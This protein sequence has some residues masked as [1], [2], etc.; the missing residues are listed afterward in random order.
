MTLQSETDTR[1][2]MDVRVAAPEHAVGLSDLFSRSEVS[3]HCR[4]WHFAGDKN[5]W[6]DR[7]ANGSARNRA[8]MI[9]ALETASGDMTGVVALAD[10][11]VIGWLKLSN[12][13]SLSKLYDQR[14]Y[15]NLPCFSGNRDGVF[16]IGCVLVDPAR[17]RRGVARALLRG[18]VE[19]ARSLGGSTIEALPRR[20][21]DV[22][23]AEL[24]LGPFSMFVEA[25]FEVVHDFAP[26]PVLRLNL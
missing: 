22:A 6:L 20:A 21:D 14:L 23:D 25:G 15:K 16:T 19:R 4:Y 8:E 12:A 5:A 1:V 3:C 24:W 2:A 7:M 13:S 26:Y 17:R 11:D 9:A 10:G 18:A